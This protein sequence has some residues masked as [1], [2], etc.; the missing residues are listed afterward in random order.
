MFISGTEPKPTWE[1]C[2]EAARQ[3]RQYVGICLS[4]LCNPA[5]TLPP[6]KKAHKD[7]FEWRTPLHV[8]KPLREASA[9]RSCMAL[10]LYR[11]ELSAALERAFYSIP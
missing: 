1:S 3:S 6:D 9:H 10:A 4:T 7:E 2:L 11:R 5:A 8:L